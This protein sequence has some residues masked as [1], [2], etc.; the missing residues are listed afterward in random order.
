MWAL[1]TFDFRFCSNSC[2]L[3]A[4]VTESAKDLLCTSGRNGQ[5]FF[6]REERLFR[7]VLLSQ[8]LRG[9]THEEVEDWHK[10]TKAQENA[11]N[12]S[13]GKRC[14]I[15][16]GSRCVFS[17]QRLLRHGR[18]TKRK[19]HKLHNVWGGGR[20]AEA[21]IHQRKKNLHIWRWNWNQ[22]NPQQTKTCKK[23]WSGNETK[24]NLKKS[25]EYFWGFW[26][27]HR[28]SWAQDGWTFGWVVQ[29]HTQV[30]VR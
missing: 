8:H 16:G 3:S 23:C 19:W 28:Y 30:D 18:R 22:Y 1:N 6:S 25:K 4:P 5:T 10:A 20:S 26:D 11:G 24:L 13:T 17:V 12:K 27:G 7:G 14:K 2:N 15:P 29:G 21:R 9:K